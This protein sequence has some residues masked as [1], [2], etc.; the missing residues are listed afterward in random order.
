VATDHR[1]GRSVQNFLDRR[2][3]VDVDRFVFCCGSRLSLSLKSFQ[4]EQRGH[5]REH[6]RLPISA[7]QLAFQ[8]AGPM[9]IL[10]ALLVRQQ[11]IERG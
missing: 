5:F 1:A 2:S 4:F 8:L 9:P 11:S 7:S 10:S 3:V 6:G